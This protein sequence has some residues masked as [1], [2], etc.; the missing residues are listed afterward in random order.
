M[1]KLKKKYAA[2][3]KRP[4]K[5]KPDFKN[6]LPC[7]WSATLD[8]LFPQ[9]DTSFLESTHKKKLIHKYDVQVEVEVEVEGNG[10]WG[11]TRTRTE[12]EIRTR[13][14]QIPIP[15]YA[16]WDVADSTCQI[17]KGGYND[18]PL[19]E[20]SRTIAALNKTNIAE[21]NVRWGRGKCLTC[22]I[23]TILPDVLKEHLVEMR[24][25]IEDV[26]EMEDELKFFIIAE[27]KP[28]FW[29]L[30]ELRDADPMLVATAFGKCWL[31]GIWD[32]TTGEEEVYLTY[33]K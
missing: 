6:L 30:E 28:E 1:F 29:R 18:W 27:T 15:R 21:N 33:T 22:Q 17:S 8:R 2:D 19:T 14:I 24:E 12:R 16:V 5:K 13:K 7:E 26:E 3:V 11:G 10:F 25:A 20:C 32:A 23:T 31:M 9:L 4:L